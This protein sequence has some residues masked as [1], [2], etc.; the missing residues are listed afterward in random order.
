MSVVPLPELPPDHLIVLVFGPGK[1]EL[2]LVRAP[3]DGW[4]V[5]DGCGAGKIDYA[6]ATLQHYGALPRIVLLTHPHDDHSH[7]MAS[8][9]Q[10][11]TPR[12]RPDTW[13]RIGMVLPHGN[14]VTTAPMDFIARATRHAIAA[15]ESRWRASPACRWDV[16][17]G[18][19]EPLGD[20]T[21]RVL[22]PREHVRAEQLALWTRRQSFDKNVLSTALLVTWQTR[23]LLLGSD[24]V[25]QPGGGWAHCIEIEPTIAEHDLLK[26]PHHGSDEALHD[27]VLRT[28]SRG[29]A[30]LRIF[31]PYSPSRLPRFS[32]GEGVHRVASLGGTSYLTGLPRPHAEQSGHAEQRSLAALESHE[33]ISFAPA[34]G[35]Y[36]DCYVMFAFPADGGPPS[37]EQG[38]GS[39]RVDAA[40]QR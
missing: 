38:P 10:A 15:V 14:D 22:S 7:G 39:I 12:D 36:P 9:L 32:P 24:L 26:V 16:R 13:P 11:A 25:E 19:Q 21:I 33:G 23:R 1:G 29:A 4:M 35:G 6:L 18:E 20:A 27:D 5:V 17:L 37:V 28:G 2:V 30:P 40:R 3:P 34:T 8:V 31:T